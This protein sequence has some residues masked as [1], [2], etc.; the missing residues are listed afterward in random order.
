M[1]QEYTKEE[2]EPECVIV[3]QPDP[4][5]RYEDDELLQEMQNA[6]KRLLELDME[7]LCVQR[8]QDDLWSFVQKLQTEWM[9]RVKAKEE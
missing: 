3:V 9:R 6:T 7:R 4:I 2:E 5:K 8:A 1:G